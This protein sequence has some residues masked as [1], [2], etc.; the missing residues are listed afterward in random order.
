[1]LAGTNILLSLT[2][3]LSLGEILAVSVLWW[4]FKERDWKKYIVVTL[5]PVVIVLFYYAHAPKYQFSFGLSPEQ[6]IR[7]NIARQYFEVIFIFLASL[8]VYV[9]GQKTVGPS[10]PWVRRY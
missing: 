3:I 5:L 6:L 9:W 1:M 7:D 8:S 2:S 4:A 10:S